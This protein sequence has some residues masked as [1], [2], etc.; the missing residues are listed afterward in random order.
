MKEVF[1]GLQAKSVAIDTQNPERLA[2]FWLAALEWERSAEPQD[3]DEIAI[4]APGT[5]DDAIRRLLF[6]KVPEAKQVKNR[7]HLDLKPDDQKAEVA[8][9]LHLGATHS[10]IGQTGNETWVVLADP[11]GNEFCVLRSRDA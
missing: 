2:R 10:E 4:L 8:R 1:V 5:R 9:L 3:D 6:L 7:L 11:D